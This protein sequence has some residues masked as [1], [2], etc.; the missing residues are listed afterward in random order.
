MTMKR[1]GLIVLSGCMIASLVSCGSSSSKE[2]ARP[3]TQQEAANLA[4]S[5]H[6]N[7]VKGGA[8]FT[9]ST[10]IAPGQG[11][12]QVSGAI[13][14]KNHIGNASVSADESNSTLTGIAWLSK[15]VA[16]RRPSFDNQLLKFGAAQPLA[17]VR[18]PNMNRRI[19][20]VIS[21]I[22]GLAA[23]Q[24]ENSQLILQKPGSVFL[25]DDALRGVDVQV[26]RYGKRNVFWIAED[27]GLLLRFEGSNELGNQP[28]LIDFREHGPQ[29]V[30]FPAKK[31]W[32][33]AE[34]DDEIMQLT[35][36]F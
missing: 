3:L 11:A 7:Y 16:E 25:R 33:D 26:L 31:Y 13:D 8:A 5:L 18:K 12:L 32:V 6:L 17:I 9:V 15:I 19:D 23:E 2:M 1:I 4:Q 21:I 20:Q 35:S 29:D 28:I 14:W 36:G 24:P 10:V 22:M 34:S 30:S 27:T